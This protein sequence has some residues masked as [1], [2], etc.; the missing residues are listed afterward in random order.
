M[1]WTKTVN[2]TLVQILCADNAQSL[3]LQR[4]LYSSY[5]SQIPPGGSFPKVNKLRF[6]L[7]FIP[8]W[9][10]YAFSL[11]FSSIHPPSPCAP[12]PSP[13]RQTWLILPTNFK[14]E[15]SNFSIP[16]LMFVYERIY[17]FF[18]IWLFHALYFLFLVLFCWSWFFFIINTG[19][20]KLK[21]TIEF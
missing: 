13:P 16:R 15:I 14:I 6:S 3:L 1:H 21:T 11:R 4:M 18:L 7:R 9:I 2:F 20:G 17:V 19:K 10:N 8:K 5:F 12:S